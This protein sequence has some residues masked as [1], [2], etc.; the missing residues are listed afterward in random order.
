LPFKDNALLPDSSVG[1]NGPRS[2]RL[3]AAALQA[4]WESV[5]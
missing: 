3:G 2:K 1:W 4:M 5:Q